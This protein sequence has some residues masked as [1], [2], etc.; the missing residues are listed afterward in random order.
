DRAPAALR[1]RAARGRLAARSCRGLPAHV[2]R[3]RRGAHPRRGRALRP[4]PV[5]HVPP[6]LRAPR[7]GPADPRAPAPPRGAGDVLRPRPDRRAL[8]AGGGGDPRGRP[9]GRLPHPRPPPAAEAHPGGRAGGLRARPGRPAPGRGRAARVPRVLLAAHGDGARGARRPRVHPRPVA[10]GRRPALPAALRGRRARRAARALAHGRLGAVRV[11]PRPADRDAP[12]GPGA[13]ARGLDRR[14]GRHAPHG[15]AL[16]PHRAPV[17]LG[18][19]VARGGHRA[20]RR[21]RPRLRGR[22]PGPRRPRGGRR[23]RA[24]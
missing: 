1:A 5:D 12:A 11:P 10:H 2:R 21:V 19:A 22:A 4:R 15:L 13:G 16:R 17:R 14:A 8:A 18:P 6:G 24:L 23:A 9:R 20:L 3:G 7:R